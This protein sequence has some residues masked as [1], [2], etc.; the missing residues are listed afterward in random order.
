MI[1]PAIGAL[2]FVLLLA[3]ARDARAGGRVVSRAEMLL[4]MKSSRGFDPTATTNNPRFQAEVL[5]QLLRAAA[6]AGPE[7]AHLF[8]D[9][10]DWFSAYLERTGLAAGEAPL[11]ARLAREHRQDL[12]L[13]ARPGRVI[14]R[15]VAG[16]PPRLAAN[17]TIGWPVGRPAKQRYSYDDTLAI[18]DLRVTNERV[19]VYRLVDYGDLVVYDEIEGLRGRPTEGF[20]GFL[21]EMIGEGSVR[22]NRMA[23]SGDGLQVSRARATKGP[24]GVE[25]TITVFPDGRVEKDLTPGRPDLV[26]LEKRLLEKREVRYHPLRRDRA[27]SEPPPPEARRAARRSRR[28]A[29]APPRGLARPRARGRAPAPRRSRRARRAG[30]SR[31]AWRGPRRP[32]G[33]RRAPRAR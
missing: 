9:H 14:E 3:G 19:I 22:W 24:F 31:P 8:L 23:I 1:G 20:L 5:L 33:S 27:P 32:E 13:D 17:V 7:A 30:G 6:P 12:E 21:F 26:P 11:F 29:A 2:A 25:S 15:V 16:P 28:A 4:A 18:P 10:E